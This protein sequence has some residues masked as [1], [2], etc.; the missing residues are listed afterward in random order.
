M[1]ITGSDALSDA[2]KFFSRNMSKEA[3]PD[4]FDTMRVPVAT[5]SHET[6]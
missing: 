6:E 5:L 2:T 3:I 4:Q 1:T